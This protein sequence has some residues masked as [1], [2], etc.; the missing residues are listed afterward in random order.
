MGP[1]AQDRYL[2][3]DATLASPFQEEYRYAP[4]A[5]PVARP[6]LLNNYKQETIASG[7]FDMDWYRPAAT[8][9]AS[10]GF[11]SDQVDMCIP[12]AI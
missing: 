8:L 12:T 7:G 4:V 3:R 1:G 6:L 5:R 2:R 11:S 9:R 10:H